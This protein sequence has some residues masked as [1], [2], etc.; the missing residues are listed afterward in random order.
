MS[1]NHGVIIAFFFNVNSNKQI[2]V[3]KLFLQLGKKISKPYK[4]K[5]RKI[6]TFLMQKIS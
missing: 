2:I 3:K 1:C 4:R 5:A 6:R